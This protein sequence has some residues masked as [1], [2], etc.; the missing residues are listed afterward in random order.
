LERADL[1]LLGRSLE[2]LARPVEG[3]VAAA[4]G[5]WPALAAGLPR[6]STAQLRLHVLAA[7]AYAGELALPAFF[8][9]EG[10]L[11]GPAAGIGALLKAYTRLVQRG[12]WMT[13]A[14]VGAHDR[15]S[16][17]PAVSFLRANSGLYIYCI[18]DGHYDLSLVGKDLTD[19]YRK[20]GGPAA[21]GKALTAGRVQAL[22]DTYS[23]PAVRL[24]PHPPPG[25]HV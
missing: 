4:R 19:A 3:E 24:E 6:E 14:T 2:R 9:R 15:P 16:R 12:W 10:G 17:G 8:T 7:N 11:T 20:L 22:A 1:V 23:I 21:F 18:Y 5:A 13:A 25:V